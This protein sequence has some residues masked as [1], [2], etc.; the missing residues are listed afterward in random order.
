M[1]GVL[2]QVRRMLERSGALDHLGAAAIYPTLR[3]AVEVYESGPTNL[4]RVV[5]AH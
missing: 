2:P 5:P 4:D 3:A 1:A